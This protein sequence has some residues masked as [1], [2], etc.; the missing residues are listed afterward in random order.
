MTVRDKGFTLIEIIMTIVIIGILAVIVVA[1]FINMRVPAC[2]AKGE[3]NIGALRSAAA[4]YYSKTILPQYECLC[5]ATSDPR[6]CNQYGRT[7]TSGPPCYPA[8]IDELESLLVSPPEWCEGGG[9]CY[10]DETGNI[11][12]CN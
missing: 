9:E 12:M 7:T 5:Y 2:N 1:R 11:T 4:V 8:N 3:A 6:S 10:D